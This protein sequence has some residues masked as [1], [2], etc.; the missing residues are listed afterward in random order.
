MVPTAVRP[1]EKPGAQLGI[2][3]LAR[4]LLIALWRYVETG[5]VPAGAEVVKKKR[6]VKTRKEVV[7]SQAS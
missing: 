7:A 5:E 3:A 1:G 6:V 2:V 4:K